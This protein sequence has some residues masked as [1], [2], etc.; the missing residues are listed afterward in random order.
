MLPG[1][2]NWV[3]DLI[4]S[5]SNL[6]RLSLDVSFWYS[7]LIFLSCDKLSRLQELDPCRWHVTESFFKF[8][9]CLR[10]SLRMLR[11]SRFTVNSKGHLE[12]IFQFLKREF[13]VLETIS[14]RWLSVTGF[15]QK[16]VFPTL[17]KNPSVGLAGGRFTVTY[18]FGVSYSGPRIGEALDMK[19]AFYRKDVLYKARLRGS[20]CSSRRLSR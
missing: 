14:V 11:L 10:D 13:S 15:R 17:S 5:A 2:L 4:L 6:Q 3:V 7:N 18:K 8:L 12:S 9:L 1:N 19:Q 20:V 16:I